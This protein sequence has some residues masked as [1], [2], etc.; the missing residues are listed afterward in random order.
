MDFA[1]SWM[2][3]WFYIIIALFA[4]TPA[5]GVVPNDSDQTDDSTGTH[6]NKERDTQWQ[7]C[8]S[9]KEKELECV[10]HRPDSHE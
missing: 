10:V 2:L 1:I 4:R 6:G 7:E 3:F 9:Q 5:L 8:Q